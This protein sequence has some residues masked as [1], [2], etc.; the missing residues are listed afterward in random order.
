MNWKRFTMSCARFFAVSLVLAGCGGGS[1]SSGQTTG[2]PV[3][4][5]AGTQA[6]YVAADQIRLSAGVSVYY[7]SGIANPPMQRNIFVYQNAHDIGSPYAT[8]LAVDAAGYLY[9][10][11]YG[12]FGVPFWTSVN[13]PGSTSPLLTTTQVGGPIA[14]DGKNN[15]YM[16]QDPSTIVV[17]PPIRSS[18]LPAPSRSISGSATQLSTPTGIAIDTN[19]NLYVANQTSVT[20]YGP[21]ASG[22]V[23]PVRTIAGSSTQFGTLS[24]IAVDRAGRLYVASTNAGGSAI[25]MFA[26]GANG[27]V[28]PLARVSAGASE[29]A[30]DSPGNVYAAV[31]GSPVEIFSPALASLV[32]TI[33]TQAGYWS[34]C[35]AVTVGP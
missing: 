11:G 31:S 28:A 1:G 3:I 23:A 33:P 29:L 14:V 19:D 35:C 22:N 10:T 18:T 16:A 32:G 9:A 7:P 34:E 5:V 4:P 15:L 20:V 25:L 2:L 6:V 30:V 12:G 13:A 17:Y 8:N 27:N 26:S 21:N 24:A